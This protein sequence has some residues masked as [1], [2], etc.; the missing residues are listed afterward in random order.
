L[1]KRGGG[2]VKQKLLGRNIVRIEMRPLFSRKLKLVRRAKG[3]GKNL[4][5]QDE[6]EESYRR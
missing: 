5:L 2:K 4:C 1:E 6:D 3:K